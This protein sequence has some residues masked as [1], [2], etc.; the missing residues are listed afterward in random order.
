LKKKSEEQF[1][2]D[3]LEKEAIVEDALY[4]DLKMFNFVR[5][6]WELNE[7]DD[8]ESAENTRKELKPE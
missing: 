7:E 3:L 4:Q 5:I 6:M 2:F 1:K 8:E